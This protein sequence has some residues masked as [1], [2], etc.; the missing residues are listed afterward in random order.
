LEARPLETLEEE[1]LLE[2]AQELGDFCLT[3]MKKMKEAHP[4]IGDVRGKGLLL[5]IELVK[6]PDTKEPFV[7]GGNKVYQRAFQKGLA[8][9]LAKH[10]LRFA[11]ALVM[12]QDVAAKG[13]DIIEEAIAEVEDEYGYSE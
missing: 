1:G 4:I 3:R 9:V 6:D 13:L 7:D 5:G 11:P 10:T 2:H 12:Q 8:W